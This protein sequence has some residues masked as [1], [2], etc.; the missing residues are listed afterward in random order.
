MPAM[1]QAEAVTAATYRARQTE[2]GFQRA[3]LG[4]AEALGWVCVHFP[5]MLA[6]P[7]GWPDLLCFR[8]G[9]CLLMELK[10]ENGRLGPKQAEWIER[11][12]AV[13]ID[14]RVFRP[15]QWDAIE[16]TLRG[17]ER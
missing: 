3:V 7:S 9:R 15:S 1:T 2:A 16:T 10:R 5:A 4:A 6:N 13:G 11:L 12:A 8:D 14:V 17:E